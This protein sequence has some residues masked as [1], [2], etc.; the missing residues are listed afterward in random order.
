[1]N[2]KLFLFAVYL[3]LG[4]C[5]IYSLDRQEV[6]VNVQSTLQERE[7]T[8][9]VVDVNGEPIIGANVL[10]RGQNNGVI[11]DV[12]GKF[13]LLVPQKATL[14]ISYIGYTTQEVSLT[15]K[16]SYLITLLED[17]KSLDEVVVVG[18][19]TMKKSDLT[20]SVASVKGDVITASASTSITD[21]LQGKVPG[22]DIQ[23]SR[24]E[25]DNREIRIRGSR[26]LNASNEPLVII[27]GVPGS[28]NEVNTND[29]KSI[30]VLKDASSAAIY[31]SRG[32]NG[33]IIITT[34]RGTVGKTT[35]SYDAFYGINK[36][37]FMKMMSGDKFVQ[38]RRDVY[39]IAN[40]LWG[41][42]VN[43]ENIFSDDELQ[44]IHDREYYDWQDLIF[45]NGTIQKH[46]L[47][48]SSGSE[49]TKF[50]LSFAYEKETGYNQNSEASK[51]Y[52]TSTIDHKV[53]NW[54]D[55][56]T[57]IRLRKRNSSGFATYGQALFYGT[58]LS[59]PYDE[60][61]DLIMYP[62]PQE[63]SVS[64]LADFVDGQYAND[65]ENTNVN[66]VFS[67]NIHPFKGL[68]LQSN[69]GYTYTDTK[70]GFLLDGFPRTL[71]QAKANATLVLDAANTYIGDILYE[72]VADVPSDVLL[73]APL[74]PYNNDLDISLVNSTFEDFAPG[75]DDITM[76]TYV[77]QERFIPDNEYVIIDPNWTGGS[78]DPSGIPIYHS[79]EE[80]ILN[81]YRST[82]AEKDNKLVE[83]IWTDSYS[84]IIDAIISIIIMKSLNCLINR[85]K[86]VSF[87]F[88]FSLFFPYSFCLFSTSCLA[89]PP[90]L[91]VFSFCNTSS[92]LN[93]S[94]I[95][96]SPSY[97]FIYYN[98]QL[99]YNFYIYK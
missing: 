86:I 90:L 17:T 72:D 80:A 78:S 55:F 77:D 76:L 23:S 39:K 41:Q 73:S 36:P 97:W 99:L 64:V 29:I 11:T 88:S 93:V 96:F 30:E 65:T 4:I 32:A 89:S 49:K 61:G 37:Q 24:Y 34:K 98:S 60:N 45:R 67:A 70:N 54:L 5:P 85:T 38:L 92:F 26:S 47:S 46:N 22:M 28:M 71:D 75:S 15:N 40:N 62:N 83:S 69:L 50:S 56:G 12:D 8:G 19:G 68:S 31:G 82:N 27:D 42:E 81:N 1:M 13:S 51:F 3:S 25:G 18:Y 6:D 79:V 84:D 2:K 43:D 53:T 48:L 87:G 57:A 20:A 58:P 52:L 35:I 95:I 63:S 14:R 16:S 10:V 9:R 91:S 44:M 21:A 94:H 7:I 74:N 59:R 33:V 66:L